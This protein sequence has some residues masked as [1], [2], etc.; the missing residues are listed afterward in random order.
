MTSFLLTFVPQRLYSN[1]P[2]ATEYTTA[3]LTDRANYRLATE[4][5]TGN[6]PAKTDFG[7]VYSDRFRWSVLRFRKIARPTTCGADDGK[8]AYIGNNTISSIMTNE[9]TIP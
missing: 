1:V 3:N 6:A 2:T 5:L 7:I 8:Q 9:L 4:V